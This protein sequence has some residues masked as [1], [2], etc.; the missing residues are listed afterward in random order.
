M[1]GSRFRR[2]GRAFRTSASSSD[3]PAASEINSMEMIREFGIKRAVRTMSSLA[4]VVDVEL[5][6]P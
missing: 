5:K 1:I 3:S 2:G 4:A 6:R